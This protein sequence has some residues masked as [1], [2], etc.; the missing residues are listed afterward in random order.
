MT[1]NTETLDNR[2]AFAL[3]ANFDSKKL[4]ALIDE[5]DDASKA[6]ERARA[7][8]EKSALDPATLSDDVDTA[9][10][11]MADAD[12]RIR[13]L[14]AAREKLVPL[15]KAADDRERQKAQQALIDAALAE[16][17]QLVADI[18]EQYPRAA[19]TIVDLLNRIQ[20]NQQR[21]VGLCGRRERSAESIARRAPENWEVNP[22]VSRLLPLSLIKLPSMYADIND[23]HGFL[24]PTLNGGIR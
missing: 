15:Y 2:I 24:Y 6:A 10:T 22:G 4:E 21:L 16:R 7:E 18:A 14:S 3:T 12:F 9:R 5:V 1:D 23:A 13:R 20:A 19:K 11:A 17:D 8:A